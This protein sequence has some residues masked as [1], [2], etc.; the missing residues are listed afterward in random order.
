MAKRKFNL[1]AALDTLRVS[2]RS[3]P[4]QHLALDQLLLESAAAGDLLA[5]DAL[6]SGGTGIAA[7]AVQKSMKVL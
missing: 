1:A 6:L 3:T 5:V 7:G 2:E 4:D